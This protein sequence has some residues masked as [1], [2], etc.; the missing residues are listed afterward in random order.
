MKITVMTLFPEMIDAVIGSSILGRARQKGLIEIEAIN[1]RDFANNKHLQ[2]D[3]YPY[4]GGAG[5]LMMADPICRCYKHIQE[6]PGASPTRVIYM[7]PQGK[8]WKQE[9]AE[10]FASEEHIVLLC[11]HYEGIDQRAIDTIV[12]DEVSIGDYVLTGGEL[13]ALVVADSISR[14]VPGVLGKEESFQDESFSDGLLEYPHYTRPAVY[15]GLAVP[16]VL[17]SGN[18]QKIAAYR[19]EQS[20]INTFNKRPDLLKQAKLS[21][22]EKQFIHDYAKKRCKS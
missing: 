10:S 22:K 3:D 18:H 5:M 17:L 8:P 6:T 15:E 14:L 20:L 4:G 9:M 21:D 12:T 7:T 16:D 1:I 2:V 13:A 19:R 11:G